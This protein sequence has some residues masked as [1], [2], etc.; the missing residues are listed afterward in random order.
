MPYPIKNRGNEPPIHYDASKE[1]QRLR[2]ETRVAII[3][4]L[5]ISLL[6]SRHDR[7]IGVLFPLLKK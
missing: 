6:R 1:N 5:L 3:R 7:V 4:S 2:L